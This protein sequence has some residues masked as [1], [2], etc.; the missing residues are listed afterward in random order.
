MKLSTVTFGVALL[1]GLSGL[2]LAIL[3]TAMTGSVTTVQ[4]EMI[5]DAQIRQK[6]QLK[7]YANVQISKHEKSQIE[8]TATKDGNAEKLTVSPQ[9]GALMHD[10]DS[11]GD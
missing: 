1:T 9:I 3:D 2:A 7:G 6:L 11:D 4:A 10:T 5:T 8:A